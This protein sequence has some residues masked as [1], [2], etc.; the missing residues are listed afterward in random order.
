MSNDKMT[1]SSFR[2]NIVLFQND[3][4]EETM[5]YLSFKMTNHLKPLSIANKEKYMRDLTNIEKSFTTRVDA[6]IANNFIKESCI[7][8]CNSISLFEL[9]YFDC[10]FYSLRQS[11]EVSTT[12][13]YLIDNNESE[14][15][16]SELEK[17]NTEKSFKMYKQMLN[18]LSDNESNFREIK[19]AVNDFFERTESTKKRLNKFV[20]KQGF[21]K[22]YSVRENPFAG[23]FDNSDL[24]KYYSDCIECCI[25]TVAVMRLT[26]DPFPIL[27]KD[28]D[29]YLRTGASLTYAYTD[30][31]IDHYIGRDLVERYKTT[32]MYVNHYIDIIHNEKQSIAITD[33][34]K[35]QYVDTK[36]IDTI[37]KQGHLLSPNELFAARCISACD[38]ICKFYLHGGL[39]MY[40]TDKNTNRKLLAWDSRDFTKFSEMNTP[41][42]IEY[43]EA[44]ISY[45]KTSGYEVFIEHNEEL[46]HD[47]IITLTSQLMP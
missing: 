25:A 5:S 29:I 16:K 35:D 12:M 32:S 39:S 15:R 20:H 23:Y 37:L 19:S 9:G 22:F 17:W 33:F 36:E 47:E 26:I 14:L 13:M 3:F 4:Y 30:D 44:F 2:Y 46:S 6:W 40:F 42:N 21:D 28:R 27:F 43:N 45:I 38:K 18:F 7:L 41:F 34:I 24:T 31:F 1:E 11:I 8:I 10:A